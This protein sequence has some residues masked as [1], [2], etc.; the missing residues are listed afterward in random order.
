M[1]VLIVIVLFNGSAKLKDNLTRIFSMAGIN[2]ALVMLIDNGSEDNSA[3]IA[4]S[5]LADTAMSIFIRFPENRGVGA[6]YNRGVEEARIRGIQWMMILDQDTETSSTILLNLMEVAMK[7]TSL[8]HRVA[9]VAPLVVNGFFT[10]HFYH[11]YLWNGLSL[12]SIDPRYCSGEIVQI[13]STITSGTLYNVNALQDVSCFREDYFI[14]FIDHECH[15]RLKSRG[16][17]LWCDKNSQ[18]VHYIGNEQR[19]TRHG[20]WVEHL[21][22]RYFFMVRNMLDGYFRLSGLKGSVC[23]LDQMRVHLMLILRYSKRRYQILF[24]ISRGI[25]AF[26]LGKWDNIV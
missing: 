8:G 18:I 7:V 9:G 24:H 10:E 11:P 20:I 1:N 4:E 17:Q 22:F 14:D 16:W 15:I 3:D 26:L 19:I 21:P 2:S 6:A 25:K 5:F 23:F 12:V 13:D